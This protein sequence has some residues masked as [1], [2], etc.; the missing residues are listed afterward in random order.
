MFPERAF[1]FCRYNVHIN[2]Q[3]F[4]LGFGLKKVLQNY[5]YNRISYLGTTTW[6]YWQPN[7]QYFN[8]SG[9]LPIDLVTTKIGTNPRGSEWAKVNLPKIP[10]RD[11]EWA[12]KDLVEVPES[13]EPGEY[14][15][16][17]RW[18]CQHTSQVWNAC[19][20]IEIV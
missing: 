18:D 16:S 2:Q 12:F 4:F 13:L 10:D 6:I 9:W 19:A 1:R 15:L 20:N 11:D 7:N 14:V 3:E 17:F 8:P 5:K